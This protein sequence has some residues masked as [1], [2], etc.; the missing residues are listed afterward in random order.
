MMFFTAAG[1]FGL[2]LTVHKGFVFPASSPTPFIFFLDG[3]HPSA[4]VMMSPGSFD[5]HFPHD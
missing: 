1:P 5:L 4:F 2:P 3:S